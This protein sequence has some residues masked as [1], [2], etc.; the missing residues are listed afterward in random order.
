MDA[1]KKWLTQSQPFT[2]S[3]NVPSHNASSSIVVHLRF[4]SPH[5]VSTAEL[6]LNGSSGR[7]PQSAHVPVG[8]TNCAP[9]LGQQDWFAGSVGPGSTVSSSG[10][11][12]ACR[13]NFSVAFRRAV[14]THCSVTTGSGSF[15]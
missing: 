7:P 1:D 5:S 2:R 8:V 4:P 9:H 10:F 6:R 11:K 14:R 15:V 3:I 13:R 12:P